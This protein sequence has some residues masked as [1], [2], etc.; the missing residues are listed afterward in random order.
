M[1]EACPVRGTGVEEAC[2]VRGTR[3]EVVRGPGVE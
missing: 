1:E 3:V 2:P